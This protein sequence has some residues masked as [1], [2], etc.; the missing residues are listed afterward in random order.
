[1][2]WFLSLL[3][4]PGNFSH[5][6]LVY[7]VVIGIGLYL[8]RLRIFGISLGLTCV[9]FLGL[10]ASNL[11]IRLDPN[12]VGYFRNFG[13]ILFVFF[14]GL[15]VGPS[16]FATFKQGGVKLN[17]L[18]ALCIV[19]SI[20]VTL[21]LYAFFKD[22]ISLP[23]LLG[24]HF[25]AITSTPGLGAAQ[26]ALQ[27]VGYNGI[28][29]GIGYACAYPCGILGSI[30]AIALL[31][32]IFRVDIH[33]EDRLW[34]EKQ[35]RN[36]D[37][38]IFFH[39]SVTNESLDLLTLREIRQLIGRPFIC[40]RILHDGTI[41][42]PTANTVVHASDILRIVAGTEHKRAICV[43]CGHEEP[44]V[45]L[46]TEHSPLITKHILVTREEINGT[47]IEE[48]HLSRLDGVNITRVSRAG[49]TFFPYNSLRLQLGDSLTCVGPTNSVKRLE[50]LMGNRTQ[51]LERPNVIA[52]FFGLALGI[53]LGSLPIW[54]PGM[55]VS[56]KLG[57]AGGPL[58]IAIL[59]GY[60]GPKFHLVTYT[61]HSANLMLREWGLAFFLASIGFS[62][63]DKFF[64]A[65]ING[66][67]LMYMALGIVVTLVPILLVGSIARLKLKMNFH[68]VAGLLSGIMTNTPTLAYA[69]SISEKSTAVIAYSTVYPFAM[70]L[71]ILSG[72]LILMLMWDFT[73]T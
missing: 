6:L 43:F 53:I 28:D 29:I 2:D 47:R 36:S 38:P 66:N 67:G 15:Q 11:G 37:V 17:S 32:K 54:I 51:Q 64:D 33:E 71:R 27:A 9:L 73:I 7:S 4:D 8:G 72:Q 24:V 52:I 1:M 46:A 18:M 12:I 55:P 35:R 42:S 26:E 16:F 20:A 22:H 25:G 65:I 56:I 34:E 57:L 70:F 40:S 10:V 14:I 44:D 61:T 59:L 41:T 39:V 62:A 49:M 63:G 50:A 60:F 48:L 30:A 45:D 3:N 13:L 68:E 58:I 23:E 31:K 5:N 19:T 69:S 21:I